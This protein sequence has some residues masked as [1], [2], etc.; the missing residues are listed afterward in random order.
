MEGLVYSKR[1]AGTK[2]MN[3][4][5]WYNNNEDSGKEYKGLAAQIKEAKNLI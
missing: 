2:I 3:R 5:F 4:K 1:G